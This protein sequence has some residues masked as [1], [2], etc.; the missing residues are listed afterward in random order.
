MILLCIIIFSG[1]SRSEATEDVKVPIATH[2]LFTFVTLKCFCDFH[3]QFTL[4]T[5][6]LLPDVNISFPVAGLRPSYHA[7]TNSGIVTPR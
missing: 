6:E 4:L 3:L 5:K 2:L 7:S 1:C